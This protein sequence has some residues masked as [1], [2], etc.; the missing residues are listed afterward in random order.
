MWLAAWLVAWISA[1]AYVRYHFYERPRR[2]GK[3]LRRWGYL[4]RWIAKLILHNPSGMYIGQPKHYVAS[5]RFDYLLINRYDS[6][7]RCIALLGGVL[8]QEAYCTYCT[9]AGFRWIRWYFEAW[10]PL[11]SDYISY[12]LY[13]VSDYILHLERIIRTYMKWCAQVKKIERHLKKI[14][15]ALFH[16]YGII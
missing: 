11:T 13:I 7:F 5:V 2:I 6:L 1:Y 3:N 16:F 8:S 9:G 14:R 4:W 10:V 12:W 15:I